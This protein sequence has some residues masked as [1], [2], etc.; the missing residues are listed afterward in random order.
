MFKEACIFCGKRFCGVDLVTSNLLYRRVAH[1]YLDPTP[2]AEELPRWEAATVAQ[3]RTGVPVICK[4]TAHRFGLAEN[5]NCPECGETDSVQHLLAECPAYAAARTRTWGG[6][7]TTL[8]DVFQR[9]A[10][11]IINFLGAV[12]RAAPP[13]RA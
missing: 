11:L 3:L 5:Q 2:G 10:R 6:P 1:P 13:R 7:V 9:P 4:D 12:G 8:R